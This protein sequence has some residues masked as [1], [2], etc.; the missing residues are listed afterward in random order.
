M[1]STDRRVMCG[2]YEHGACS[3]AEHSCPSACSDANPEV[4]YVNNAL[5]IK[6]LELN[7][8]QVPNQ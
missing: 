6:S 1:C 4:S 8:I 3:P 7:R 2:A 5:L